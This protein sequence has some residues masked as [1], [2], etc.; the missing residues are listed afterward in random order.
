ML[1]GNC[2]LHNLRL[3]VMTSWA[4]SVLLILR[5]RPDFAQRRC[6]WTPHVT[7][8]LRLSVRQLR[9]LI[10]CIQCRSRKHPAPFPRNVVSGGGMGGPATRRRKGGS[11]GRDLGPEFC[12]IWSS[13]EKWNKSWEK[14]DA[15]AAD[16]AAL[17]CSVATVW[18]RF[19]CGLK[20]RCWGKCCCLHWGD[21][22]RRRAK[23]SWQRNRAFP[24]PKRTL[25]GMSRPPPLPDIGKKLRGEAMLQWHRRKRLHPLC[26]SWCLVPDF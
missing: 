3:Y 15:V 9:S 26:V 5:H 25:E 16:T 6:Y 1:S 17:V 8:L 2:S 20:A 23:F 13:E 12:L 24:T 22:S 21:R 4:G 7:R 10:G 18:V 11:G 19:L 14:G